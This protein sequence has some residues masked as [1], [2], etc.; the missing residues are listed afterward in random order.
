M[1]FS[2]PLSSPADGIPSD[3][4]PKPK[5]H[6]TKQN[7][8]EILRKCAE[9]LGRESYCQAWLL[10]QIPFIERD[11]RSDIFPQVGWVETRR[12]EQNAISLAK[13]QAKR[14][15]DEAAKEAER[16]LSLALNKAEMIRANLR[17][18]IEAALEK[19]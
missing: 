13:E 2:V 3:A 16:I 9:E 11:I 5:N 6:M 12:M 19:I 4:K 18:E 17:R 8:I 7:E 14:I 15:T 10:D 1:N